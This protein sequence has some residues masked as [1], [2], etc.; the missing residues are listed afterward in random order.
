M[1]SWHTLGGIVHVL[2]VVAVKVSAESDY[3]CRRKDGNR[4]RIDSSA[5]ARVVVD[6]Q[7]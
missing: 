4:H 5:A 6:Q 2:R 1:V 3:A 7:K